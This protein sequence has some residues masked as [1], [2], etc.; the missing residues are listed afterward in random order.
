[1]RAVGR[2]QKIVRHREEARKGSMRSKSKHK[3]M[4]M[5]LQVQHKRRKKKLKAKIAEIRANKKK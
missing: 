1:M 3:R 2:V 5:K 4:Q